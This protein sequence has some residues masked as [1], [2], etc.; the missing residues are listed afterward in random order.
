MNLQ[1]LN[2]TELSAQEVQE[3]EGGLTGLEIIGL[4][5]AV[6]SIGAAIDHIS[7]QFLEGWNHPR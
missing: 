7:E 1:N 5:T 2:V 4:A 6:I 3:T